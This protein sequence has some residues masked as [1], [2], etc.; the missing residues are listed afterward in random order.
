MKI[1]RT[2]DPRLAQSGY[3]NFLG[4]QRNFCLH[5]VITALPHEVAL[6]VR[7]LQTLGVFDEL[8]PPRAVEY[9]IWAH[10]YAAAHT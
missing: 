2:K 9:S 8:P 5:A 7:R 1:W 6:V 3:R 10:R 4:L